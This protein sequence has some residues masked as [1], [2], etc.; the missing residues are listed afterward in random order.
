MHYPIRRKD[1]A[2]DQ[3][4]AMDLLASADW[5]VLSTV[6]PDGA[7]YGTPL[8]FALDTRQDQTALV[9]HAA[10]E[11]RKLDNLRQT[12][13]ASFVVVAMAELLP[14]KFSTAYAS[15]IA[16]G[17]VTIVE[18][19]EEKRDCLR[20]LVS[21]LTPRFRE[22]GEAHIEK[23]LDNCCVLRLAIESLTGKQRKT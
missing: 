1:R 2:L 22:S 15:V 5:G 8:N 18:D 14:E 23:H 7:P 11:G 13:C 4:A 21:A 3:Q 20:L 9:F 17:P 19:L 12:P 6:G 10:L 16:E